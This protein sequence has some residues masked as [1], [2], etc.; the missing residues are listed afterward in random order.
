MRVSNI[1]THTL[2]LIE[3]AVIHV[4]VHAFTTQKKK[5]QKGL[6]KKGSFRGEKKGWEGGHRGLVWFSFINSKL[7]LMIKDTVYHVRVRRRKKGRGRGALRTSITTACKKKKKMCP[8]TPTQAA[9]APLS[10]K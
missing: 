4:R 6:F 1:R 7:V 5:D 3:L 10:I 2:E 9:S 8:H